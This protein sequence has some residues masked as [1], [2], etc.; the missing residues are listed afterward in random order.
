MNAFGITVGKLH[1]SCPQHHEPTAYGDL[2][3]CGLGNRRAVPFRDL[4]GVSVFGGARYTN[5][6]RMLKVGKHRY[7]VGTPVLIPDPH[8]SIDGPASYP[9]TGIKH[10][11]GFA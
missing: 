9:A 2:G 11:P 3:F 7:A 4:N 8:V 10:F 5:R 6:L 1:P